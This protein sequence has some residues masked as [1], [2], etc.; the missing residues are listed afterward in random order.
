[1]IIWIIVAIFRRGDICLLASVPH[2]LK[3]ALEM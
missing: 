3:A 1:M 2:T